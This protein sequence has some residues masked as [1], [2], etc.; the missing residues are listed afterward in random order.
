MYRTWVGLLETETGQETGFQGFLKLS[1]TVLGP[2]DRQRVHNLAEEM[3]V[4]HPSSW[5]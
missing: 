2:G 5:L 4:Q 1:V 3:Q